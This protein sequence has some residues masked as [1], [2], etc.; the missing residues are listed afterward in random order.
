MVDPLGVNKV[1]GRVRFSDVPYRRWVDRGECHV[2]C[3]PNPQTTSSRASQIY[4]L[5][6]INKNYVIYLDFLNFRL[7]I[8]GILY[9]H[10]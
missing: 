9:C 2:N 1:V 6:R 10:A 8:I 7:C 4:H 3:Q 5:Y